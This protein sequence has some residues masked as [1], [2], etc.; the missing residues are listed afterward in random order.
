M[1][2]LASLACLAIFGAWGSSYRC[3]DADGKTH[4]GDT[5]PA[6]CAS[7]APPA[8]K[9]AAEPVVDAEARRRDRILLDS[10][11]SAQEIDL[12]RERNVEMLSSQISAAMLRIRQLETREKQLERAVAGYGDAR[13][14]RPVLADLEAVRGERATMVSAHA[15]YTQEIERMRAKFEYDKRRWIELHEK[16]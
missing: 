1:R 5:P 7:V 14:P 12:A 8:K 15:R 11:S 6:A 3:V 13:V 4:I 2:T 10:Y 9:A 16:R